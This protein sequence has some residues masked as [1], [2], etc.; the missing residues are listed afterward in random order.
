MFIQDI[1][2]LVVKIIFL[3]HLK[4]TVGFTSNFSAIKLLIIYYMSNNY[5]K[6]DYRK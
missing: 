6:E 4:V 5:Y 2:K 1:H 3:F